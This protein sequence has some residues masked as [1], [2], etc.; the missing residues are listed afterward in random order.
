MNKTVFSRDCIRMISLHGVDFYR[1]RTREC[2]GTS[3]AMDCHSCDRP[4]VSLFIQSGFLHF[5]IWNPNRQTQSLSGGNLI[6][7]QAEQQPFLGSLHFAWNILQT[8]F[9]THSSFLHSFSIIC[10][11]F[12]AK[13]ER[14]KEDIHK[15]WFTNA[16]FHLF[17]KNLTLQ[18]VN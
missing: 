17:Q 2:N 13:K 1:G 6:I 5:W 7:K 18:W 11:A 12:G 14:K 10:I 15:K 3:L 4:A 9:T 8:K 16:M